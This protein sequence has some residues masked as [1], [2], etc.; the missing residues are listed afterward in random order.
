MFGRKMSL[1][2]LKR[3]AKAGDPDSS[4]EVGSCYLNGIGTEK[5]V[6]KAIEFLKLGA[7]QGSAGAALTLGDMLERGYVDKENYKISDYDAAFL[8]FK[9]AADG[10]L[11]AGTHRMGMMYKDGRGTPQCIETAMAMITDAAERGLNKARIDLYYIYRDGNCVEKNPE[12]A[13]EYL[14]TAA[15]DGDVSAISLLEEFHPE[16]KL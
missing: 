9:I 15:E 5:D 2:K 14:R 3:L 12:K 7:E 10:G 16:E 4:F 1:W 6:E 8:L 13:L 11:A